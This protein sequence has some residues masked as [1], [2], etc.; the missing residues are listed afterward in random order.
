MLSNKITTEYLNKFSYK[1]MVPLQCQRCSCDFLKLKAAIQN[2]LRRGRNIYCSRSCNSHAKNEKYNHG[3]SAVTCEWCN[4][5]FK[6]KFREIKKTQHSFCS[7]SCAA[8]WRNANKKAG[9]RRSKLEAY[10]ENKI[11]NEYPN[12]LVE[13]NSRNLIG[14]ELDFFFPDIMLACE[15][16]GIFHYKPIYGNTKFKRTQE[17]DEIKKERCKSQNVEL[18]VIDNIFQSFNDSI[19]EQCWLRLNDAL[20][21]KTSQ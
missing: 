10:L 4:V 6:K 3:S 12:L 16:N 8:S 15:I 14:F 13:F 20:L 18:L 19:G 11:H 21:K 5:N 17:I 1:D 9:Y 7:K 2:N